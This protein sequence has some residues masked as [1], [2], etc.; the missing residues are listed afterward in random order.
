[1]V[2]N[3]IHGR[4]KIIQQNFCPSL[5]WLRPGDRIGLKRTQDGCVKFFV[6]YTDMGTI[7]QNIPEVGDFKKYF[8]TIYGVILLE[9]I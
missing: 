9:I 3:E 5:D 6:N 1:M 7:V 8:S 2:G 4:N